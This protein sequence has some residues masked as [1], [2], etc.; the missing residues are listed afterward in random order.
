MR[1]FARFASMFASMSALAGCNSTGSLELTLDLP[2]DMAL[3]PIDPTT[4]TVTAT[5]PGE[6][7][8]SNTAVLDGGAFS[9]GEM[10]TGSDVQI[11][12]VLRDVSNRL[13]GVG[14]AG[15]PV[16]ISADAPT[17]L[18]IPVRRPFVFASASDGLH[19]FDPTLDPRDASFQ[20]KITGVGAPQFSISVGGDRLAVV[21][22]AQVFIVQTETNSVDGMLTIPQGARDATAVPGTHKIAIATDTGITIADL[23]SKAVDTA[24]VGQVDRVTVGPAEDGTLYAYG[25]VGRVAPS[26]LQPPLG[27]CTGA[28]SIV[29][30][31]VEAPAAAAPKMIGGAVSDLA[32]APDVAGV[33]VTLPCAGQVAKLV[34]DLTSELGTPT[35][36]NVST[37]PGA[38]V[39]TVAGSRVWA[40]GTEPAVPSCEPGT[41]GPSS[42]ASCTAAGADDVSYAITGASLIVQSIPLDGGAPIEF[43]PPDRRET[44]TDTTDPAQQHAQVLKA[45]SVT[46]VDLVTL[47]GGQYVSLLAQSRYF[48]SALV[49]G[50]FDVVLPC[51]DAATND[52]LLF[53]LASSAVAQRVRTFCDVQV[54]PT[55]AEFP[56]W[57]CEAPP[58]AESS[59]TEYRATSIGALF[60]AR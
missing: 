31:S 55:N 3:R 44:M 45:I 57:T 14:E 15:E 56:D 2:S 32:A 54:V 39:L 34:G 12:V 58:P 36:E 7:P 29:A 30:V 21:S 17:K 33:F 18:T 38:A 13:V 53:D 46:P 43:R 35:L 22:N 11:G 41:C 59:T 16:D 37:L 48:I 49:R 24:P 4:V 51:L 19:S 47:P 5:L 28:S 23:D 6:S 1:T 40:A 25:L 27:M 52:W 20:G 9:A 26:E 50:G 8:V 10:P 60:G 42:M